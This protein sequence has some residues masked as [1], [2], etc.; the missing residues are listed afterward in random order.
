MNER[1]KVAEKWN[2][3]RWGVKEGQ[4]G[5]LASLREAAGIVEGLYAGDESG[6]ACDLE[7]F[8]GSTRLAVRCIRHIGGEVQS[9]VVFPERGKEAEIAAYLLAEAQLIYADAKEPSMRAFWCELEDREDNRESF[10]VG[11]VPAE[12]QIDIL[13][14]VYSLDEIRHITA[15]RKLLAYKTDRNEDLD[16]TWWASLPLFSSSRASHSGDE[17]LGT[18]ERSGEFMDVSGSYLA[19]SIMDFATSEE[20]MCFNLEEAVKEACHVAQLAEKNK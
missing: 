9:S 2:K 5:R 6:F 20:T 7:K 3:S 17:L 10:R 14:T 16:S 4:N 19:D 8:F 13:G 12:K 18:E 15:I 11:T 1:E